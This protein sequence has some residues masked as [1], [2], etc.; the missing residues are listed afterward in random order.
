M[1]G[2]AQSLHNSFSS[3]LPFG[4]ECRMDQLCG[5]PAK[6]GSGIFQ[7]SP[8]AACAASQS[9]RSSIGLAPPGTDTSVTRHPRDCGDTAYKSARVGLGGRGP[10]HQTRP[11]LG[12]SCTGSSICAKSALPRRPPGGP[13]RRREPSGLV[14]T[15]RGDH[16]PSASAS[17]PAQCTRSTAAHLLW[18]HC[19]AGLQ[20]LEHALRHH[21]FMS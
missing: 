6:T 17:L 18:K 16:R 14:T 9:S 11:K 5:K 7:R 19:V 3:C 4:S 1:S 21:R 20:R 12:P 2:S 13:R 8:C 15:G 10:V